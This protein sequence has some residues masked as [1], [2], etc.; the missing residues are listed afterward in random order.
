MAISSPELI[1]VGKKNQVGG[2]VKSYFLIPFL[3]DPEE[4]NMH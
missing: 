1:E 4:F 3:D 2:H